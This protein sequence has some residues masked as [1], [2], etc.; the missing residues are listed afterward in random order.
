MLYRRIFD[1][2]I[3]NASSDA[4]KRL[5]NT[6]K[7]P[8]LRN[9]RYFADLD[10]TSARYNSTLKRRLLQFSADF[11]FHS[12]FQFC[13]IQLWEPRLFDIFPDI[14]G[15]STLTPTDGKEEQLIEF[16]DSLIAYAKTCPSKTMAASILAAGW[17]CGMF[18]PVS[19]EV[20]DF[21]R[22]LIAALRTKYDVPADEDCQADERTPDANADPEEQTPASAPPKEAPAAQP[23]P[24]SRT[25]D[26]Q[27]NSS[28]PVELT[29]WD[30]ATA[31]GPVLKPI[32]F[33]ELLK[34]FSGKAEKRVAAVLKTP[35]PAEA[36]ALGAPIGKLRTRED[37]KIALLAAEE[38]TPAFF[39]QAMLAVSCGPLH[40]KIAQNVAHFHAADADEEREAALLALAELAKDIS[41]SRVPELL[42]GIWRCGLFSPDGRLTLFGRRTYQHFLHLGFLDFDLS[43]LYPDL[44]L[45]NEAG[46]LTKQTDTAD[47]AEKSEAAAPERDSAQP[48]LAQADEKERSEAPQPYGTLP[49]RQLLLRWII[50]H[51]DSDAESRIIGLLKSKTLRGSPITRGVR[52]TRVRGNNAL[53]KRILS[54]DRS[55]PGL[56]S[57][58]RLAIGEKMFERCSALYP[59]YAQGRFLDR[60]KEGRRPY[61]SELKNYID[62]A[63]TVQPAEAASFLAG[64]WPC[65]LFQDDGDSPA[66]ADA[67]SLAGQLILKKM[68]DAGIVPLSDMIRHAEDAAARA[69]EAEAR[70]AERAEAL[71]REQE[72]AEAVR[73]AQRRQAETAAAAL[74]AAAEDDETVQEAAPA[75]PVEKR[76]AQKKTGAVLPAQRAKLKSDPNTADALSTEASVTAPTPAADNVLPAAEPASAA[77]SA[78]S[79]SK[80]TGELAGQHP[81]LVQSP[82][83][84]K[85]PLR[86]PDREPTPGCERWLGFVH[87]TGTF[88]N[89]FCFAVWNPFE[90]RFEAASEESLRTRFPSLGAV[91]LKGVSTGAV[92]DGSIYAADIDFSADLKINLDVGTG[93]P[94]PDFKYR[95]DFDKLT[96]QGRMRRAS[97]IGIYRIVFPESA[98]VDFSKTIP[99]RLSFDP[100]VEPPK[101]TKAA[102]NNKVWQS[103]GISSVPVLLA[104]QGRFLGPW[105]LKE[106]AGHHPYLAAPEGLAD[107]LAPGLE[108]DGTAPDLLETHESYRAVDQIVVG[109][110]AVLDTEGL[111]AGRF[112]I[113]SD[114]ALLAKAAQAAQR[115]L[116]ASA[117]PHSSGTDAGRRQIESWLAAEH[118]ANELFPDV[119]EVSERRRARLEKLLEASGR[120]SLFTREIA[121][122]ARISM[123]AQALEKGPLFEAVLER[124]FS[125]AKTL[126]QLGASS[127]FV[128]ILEK[129]ERQVDQLAQRI[130]AE[131]IRAQA[132]L[133]AAEAEKTTALQALQD[134]QAKLAA[135]RKHTAAEFAALADL[136]AVN[137]KRQ[138]LV[139][140]AEALQSRI[141]DL[142]HSA[143]DLESRVSE[144]AQRAQN[145]I[146]DGRAA[147]K[148]MEAAADFR[149]EETEK[150]V[151]IRAEAIRRLKTSALSGAELADYLV[152]GVSAVRSYSANDILNLFLSLTQNFLTVFSG[153]PGSGK[154]S[155]CSILAHVLGLDLVSEALGRQSPKSL[156]L[157]PSPEF[158]D[159]YLPISVERGWTSKRDF[160]GY[161]NPLTKTFESVDD[162]RRDAFQAL[163]AEARLGAPKLP[164]VMLLDE[165]NL[166]PMEYYWADFMNVC[167]DASGHASISLGDHRRLKISPALRFL[168]TINNDHTTE[169]LSPRLVDRAA[170]ITLP[171]ADRAA[172]IRTPRSFTAQIIS[173]AALSSLFSAGTTPLTGAAGEGLEELISLTAAAGTPM[174]IRVQLAFEK[175]V[176]GGLPVFREDP[177]LEQ[178]AADAALDCAAA[179]RL[180]PHLSGN[181]PDYRSALVNL[182]DAAHRRRLVRTAG[183]LETMISRGDRALGYFSFF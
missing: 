4:E 66:D 41:K 101:G 93:A 138:T 57:V 139:Q 165:A 130:E 60:N 25:A 72:M 37:L 122:L 49:V 121:D 103:M 97:D 54:A 159:R 47:S 168:A 6:L 175:A 146:F 140:D 108:A 75:H 96:R 183:L 17:M 176:L 3:D 99:V 58:L 105:T 118:S 10:L 81:E 117:A 144:A 91:N 21:G 28:A 169:T 38:K 167:D 65:G 80:P 76:G 113:L 172:L 170:V 62:D 163:D 141:E 132:E 48:D 90:E 8:A 154:T 52:I 51:I 142:T 174:S 178:S 145:Y 83:P 36:L 35:Q 120:S 56:L 126:K 92:N 2:L 181:G 11:R 160:V 162:R 73:S 23:A 86:N 173:W 110:S 164:A 157:W 87:R 13:L 20:T 152:K 43:A 147:A 46:D 9:Q 74:A 27:R 85:A 123:G 82:A 151:V 128:S 50:E 148:F 68:D 77:Q 180:L 26:G 69:R 70:A 14:K 129:K 161:W 158:A 127:A 94:R 59:S 137:A 34:S 31:A 133:S 24:T 115:A 136:E 124:I 40:T 29:V 116:S 106:D 84:L 63:G 135:Q 107:G 61:L 5:L 89:F 22:A 64:A 32:L 53:M 12:E 67:L 149:R 171:A 111:K 102:K 100:A 71:R 78:V 39:E 182:L 98:E 134:E 166:S 119:A 156:A 19:N 42:A 44:L 114:R 55:D 88:V 179:S 104:Y 18:A 143:E 7:K 131:R 16:R 30:P 153:P 33:D 125:D 150:S 95:I 15:W 1:Y 109:Q 112:D 177:K 79:G 45:S 155:I